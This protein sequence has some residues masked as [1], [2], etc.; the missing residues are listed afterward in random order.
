MNVVTSDDSIGVL[1]NHLLS[2][3]FIV[4]GYK[5]GAFSAIPNN[6][7]RNW[8]DEEAK[9]GTFHIGRCSSLGVGS[10]VKYDATAQKLIVG[11]NVAG[12]LRLKFLLNGQHETKTIS[13]TIDRKSVV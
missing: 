11:K 13:T 7:F 9:E 5:D 12:G 4:I 6:F 2:K 1:P 3:Y 10:I 8:V